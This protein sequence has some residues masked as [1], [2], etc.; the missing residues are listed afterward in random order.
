MY[1]RFYNI[2]LLKYDFIWVCV[3]EDR[4]KEDRVKEVCV[5]ELLSYIFFLFA[6]IC[7]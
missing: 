5:K 6:F 2:N 4:V 7:D 1:N 3:K